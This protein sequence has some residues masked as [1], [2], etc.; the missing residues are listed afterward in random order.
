MRFQETIGVSALLGKVEHLLVQK[1]EQSLRPL[2]LTVPQ[3]SALSIIEL[4]GSMTNA[5]LS[6]ECF[7]SPQTMN[8]IIINLSKLK[9]IKKAAPRK[10]GLKIFFELTPKATELICKA[11]VIVNHIE[12]QLIKN[13]S[14]KDFSQFE[15]TLNILFENINSKEI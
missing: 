11:H 5:D 2:G 7:V 15:K 9:M 4:K 10:N 14:K 1:I 6:R 8:R 12:V 3:Y 13:I